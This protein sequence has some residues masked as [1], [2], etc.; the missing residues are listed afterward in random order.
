M[1]RSEMI[2]LIYGYICSPEFNLRVRR[3]VQAERLLEIIEQA[4]MLPP[5][6]MV[7]ATWDKWGEN[8]WEPEAEGEV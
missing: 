1:K 8:T 4:G 5:E 7:D 3:N 2:E 6:R